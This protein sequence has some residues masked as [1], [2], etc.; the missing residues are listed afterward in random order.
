MRRADLA[1]FLKARR[2]AVTP[3]EA[4]LA[5]GGRRRTPGLRREE[6]A[7]LA[8]VSVSWYTWLEQGRPINA[9]AEVLDAVA[10]VLRLDPVERDHLFELAG[11]TT[12]GVRS[13]AAD[14]TVPEDLDALLDALE[15][16]PA[17]VL[18]PRWEYLAW[19]RAQAR[20]YPAIDSLPDE[21]RNLVWSVFARP[22]GRALIV[23]WE[24]EAR[25]VLSQF[26]ADI[27]PHRDD[28]ET[29]ALVARLRGASPEFDRW[30][31]RHDVAGLTSRRRRFR[32]PDGRELTFAYQVLVA[33]GT[34]D[35]RLVVQLPVDAATRAWAAGGDP[36]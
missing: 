18:G 12:H 10:R 19:N 23:D 35:A 2:A 8:G 6:V 9:S 30:W 3:A 22:E 32:L 21:E 29:L 27:T 24:D 13:T 1:E 33:A 34:P 31:P 4:G 11:H 26:R 36:P 17:Y 7:L 16:A 25:R 28:P 5:A 20:L 14:V 15:P